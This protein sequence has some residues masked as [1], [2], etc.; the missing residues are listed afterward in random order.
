MNEHVNRRSTVLFFGSL[1]FLTTAV[2]VGMGEPPKAKAKMQGEEIGGVIPGASVAERAAFE[3]GK[4]VF[5]ETEGPEKGIG[6]VFNGTSCGECHVKGALGGAG[7][8]LVQSRV[9]RIGGMVAGKY[10]DLEN[11]GGPVLQRCGR[12]RY[13]ALFLSALKYTVPSAATATPVTT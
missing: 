10:S 9:T 11:F 3:S 4:E 13:S 1:A 6:P 2:A 8:D 7:F 5:E 12:T